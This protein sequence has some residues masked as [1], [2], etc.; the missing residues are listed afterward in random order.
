[1]KQHRLNLSFV[2]MGTMLMAL[3]ATLPARADYP[4]TVASLNPV[5]YWRLNEPVSPT[6]DYAL[7]T[8]VQC[9]R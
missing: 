6:L 9:E 2:S 8:A 1:M 4:S 7:G 3:A 5:G